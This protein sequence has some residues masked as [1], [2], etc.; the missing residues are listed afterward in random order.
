MLKMKRFRAVLGALLA[1]VVT[2]GVTTMTSKEVIASGDCGTGQ[3]CSTNLHD[4]DCCD[5]LRG[6]TPGTGTIEVVYCDDHC[7]TNCDSACE[8]SCCNAIWEHETGAHAR[9]GII[10]N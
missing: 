9:R 5:V 8:G 4:I 2:V 1:L 10:R 7:Y 3:S 6:F